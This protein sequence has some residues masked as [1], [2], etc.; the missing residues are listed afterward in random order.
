MYCY[1]IVQNYCDYSVCTYT[2]SNKQDY[3]IIVD[4]IYLPSGSF[5]IVNVCCFKQNIYN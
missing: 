1:E 3:T 4:Y 5:Y 2:K